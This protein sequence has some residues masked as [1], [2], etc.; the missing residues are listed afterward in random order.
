MTWSLVHSIADLGGSTPDAHSAFV[1]L[2]DTYLPTKGWTVGAHPGALSYRRVL[3]YTFTNEQDGASYTHHYWADWGSATSPSTLYFYNDQT[4]TT[5]PGDL[6]TTS[7]AYSAIINNATSYSGYGMPWRF[8]TSDQNA[9]AALVTRGPK[10]WFYWPGFSSAFVYE[11]DT[12]N[13][14]ASNASTCF[15]PMTNAYGTQARHAP[16]Y[17]TGSVAVYVHPSLGAPSVSTVNIG[18]IYQG[19]EFMF[20][21][22]NANLDSY[23][24][25]AYSVNQS[26][27]LLLLPNTPTTNRVIFD[28]P[29]Y[30]GLRYKIGSN[31]YL[32]TRADRSS[33]SLMF[34]FGTS[35]PDFS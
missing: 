23:S 25:R 26:D 21:N 17:T 22:S 20:A 33:N 28:T 9:N 11:D 15:L 5:T 24:C 34:D 16:I 13:G 32:G 19:F 12:W 6:A 4:Y 29:S 7:T 2:L 31:Y 8:W 30:P 35:E 1:Y 10:V 18:G 27:V 3:N 14:A